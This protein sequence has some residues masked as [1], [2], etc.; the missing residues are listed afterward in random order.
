MTT[1]GTVALVDIIAAMC[2]LP[3]NIVQ[4]FHV[5]AEDGR[6]YFRYNRETAELTLS[7]LEATAEDKTLALLLDLIGPLTCLNVDL[8]IE[9]VPPA[10]HNAIEERI[11]QLCIDR[12]VEP[13]GLEFGE[14][15]ELAISKI[16]YRKE[17]DTLK[18][19][20]TVWQTIIKK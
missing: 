13:Y 18:K 8:I 10:W 6:A 15:E 9:T 19:L 14:R 7:D 12:V 16:L 20:E 3:S 17:A 5:Q 11:K 1:L 2:K 4:R